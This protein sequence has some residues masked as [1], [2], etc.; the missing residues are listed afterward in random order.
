M[1]RLFTY[2]VLLLFVF[3]STGSLWIMVSFYANQDYIAQ[4]ICINRFDRIPVCNGKCYLS[5]QLKENEKKEQKIPNAKEKEI[6]LYFHLETAYSHPLAIV[7]NTSRNLSIHRNKIAANPMLYS[8][9]HPP[10]AA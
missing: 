6:Q 7:G 1:K 8:I 4:N 3:Q 9:F 10:K 2:L 5:S